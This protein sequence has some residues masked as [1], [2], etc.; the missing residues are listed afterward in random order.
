MIDAATRLRLERAANRLLRRANLDTKTGAE[1]D[2]QYKRG[3]RAARNAM[4]ARRQR[5]ERKLGSFGA[6][7]PVKQR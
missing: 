1:K 6:A 7:S 3:K 5:K 4:F 2:A